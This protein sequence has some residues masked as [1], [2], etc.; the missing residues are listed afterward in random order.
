MN[1]SPPGLLQQAQSSAR[2]LS[3]QAAD[4]SNGP[5]AISDGQ[6]LVPWIGVAGYLA[7]GTLGKVAR[8]GH[9]ARGISSSAVRPIDDHTHFPIRPARSSRRDIG[10]PAQQARATHAPRPT[11]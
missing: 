7:L 11:G 3:N 10:Q 6:V 8:R 9:P 1:S 4:R 2:Y 5:P